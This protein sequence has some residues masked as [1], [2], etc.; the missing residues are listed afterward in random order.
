MPSANV[1]KSS[2]TNT[3]AFSAVASAELSGNRIINTKKLTG[4]KRID[5]DKKQ[6]I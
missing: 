3:T 4:M 6:M 1:T 2:T 5:R